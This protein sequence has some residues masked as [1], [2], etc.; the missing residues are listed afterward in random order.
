MVLVPEVY[1]KSNAF[2]DIA[3]SS[4]SSSSHPKN[5]VRVLLLVPDTP[6]PMMRNSTLTLRLQ[7]LHRI[8]Q[9]EI[10]QDGIDFRSRMQTHDLA[11]DELDAPDTAAA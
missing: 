10:N 2:G 4:I 11:P 5:H 3:I 1:C 7:L 8:V 6:C 9:E